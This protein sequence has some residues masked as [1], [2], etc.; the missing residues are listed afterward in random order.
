MKKVAI[1]I[2]TSAALALAIPLYA[3]DEPGLKSDSER[4][5]GYTRQ[6][7]ADEPGM[8]SDA[9]RRSG[10]NQ[11]QAGEMQ[12]GKMITADELEGMTV[13]SQEGENIGKI[14]EITIDKQSGEVSFVTISKGGILGM[15][16][17]KIAVPLSAFEFSD[18]EARLTVSQDKLDNVPQQTAGA[19]DSD[20][21]RDLE[22][23]YG[24][25]PA[26]DKGAPGA[27]PQ[28][29][30]MDKDATEQRKQD[31]AEPRKLDTQK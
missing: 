16:A 3:A 11:Q 14:S 28:K 4:K 1:T 24:V 23:H 25:A 31:P 2:I 27:T 30:R 15:G 10:L 26:W 21:Q 22:A 12:S 19:S 9:Q 7:T 5:S 18:D 20:Y 13:V 17:S 6:Q 8:K 29:Q